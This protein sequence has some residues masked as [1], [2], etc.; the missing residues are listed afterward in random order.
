MTEMAFR[1]SAETAFLTGGR[2][3]SMGAGYDCGP[4]AFDTSASESTTLHFEAGREGVT[5]GKREINYLTHIGRW[6][7]MGRAACLT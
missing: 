4:H 3:R 6:P 5:D 2:N 1:G 7:N